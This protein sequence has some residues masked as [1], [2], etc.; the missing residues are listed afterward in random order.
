MLA[1]S[2]RVKDVVTR[3]PVSSG[4]IHR[5]VDEALV[6]EQRHLAGTTLESPA[7]DVPDETHLELLRHRIDAAPI[8]GRRNSVLLDKFTVDLGDQL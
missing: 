8:D 1:R 4:I 7:L 2:H 6:V 5:Y 3:L